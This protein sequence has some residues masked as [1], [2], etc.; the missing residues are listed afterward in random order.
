MAICHA[1]GNGG[2]IGSH[3]PKSCA[4]HIS[5]PTPLSPGSRATR[6]CVL[7]EFLLRRY[8]ALHGVH[9]AGELCEEVVTWGIN[10]T[11]PVLADQ[12]RHDSLYTVPEF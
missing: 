4:R 1:A 8:R 7:E 3:C 10:H 12:L 5:I 6:C 9:H 2:Y 11:D